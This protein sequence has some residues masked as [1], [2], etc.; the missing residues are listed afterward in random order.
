MSRSVK[1]V[2][3]VAR[4]EL[5][6]YFSTPVAEATRMNTGKTMLDEKGYILDETFISGYPFPRPSGVH[7]GWQILY[8]FDKEYLNWDSY[9]SNTRGAGV[10]R[11]FKQDYKE[12]GVLAEVKTNGRVS[13]PAPWFDSRAEKRGEQSVML[14]NALAPRDEFGNGYS[15]TSYTDPDKDNNFLLYLNLIRRVRKLSASDTQDQA[16]GLDMCFDDDTGFDQDISRSSFPFEVKILEER[17]YLVPALSLDGSSW[18]DSKNKFL[19]RDL[20]FER[21]PVYV[22]E[23]KE[24]D[25][26]Y[27]YSKRI[28]YIDQETFHLIFTMNYDQKGRLY[29]T[30]SLF[31]AFLPKMGVIAFFQDVQLDHID[32]HSTFNDTMAYP[33]PFLNRRSMSIKQ[34]MKAK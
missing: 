25:S 17:E 8:N 28:L 13:S 11:N 29:R 4:R 1:S 5:S 23:L 14:Y 19:Y 3:N 24:L 12:R 18:L 26:N 16:V 27:I 21:R 10:N 7:K 33:A 22:L 2:L 30:Y 31:P 20:K 15:R 6:G 34:L 32:I 9:L